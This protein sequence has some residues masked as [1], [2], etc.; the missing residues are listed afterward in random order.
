MNKHVFEKIAKLEKTEL[1]EVEVNLG[2]AQDIQKAIADTTAY[3]DKKKAAWGKAS[4]PLIGVFDILRMEYQSAK[5]AMDGITELE[6]KVAALGTEMPPKMVAN[7]TEI[8]NILKVSQDKI[9]KLDKIINDI[10]NV[11]F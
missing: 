3:K 8:A 11:I 5:K 9:K 7:K 2:L 1:S 6:T 4:T 10:P